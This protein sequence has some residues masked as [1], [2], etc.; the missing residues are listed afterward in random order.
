MPRALPINQS[1]YHLDNVGRLACTFATPAG[2]AV[3]PTTVSLTVKTPTTETTYVYGEDAE[4]QRSEAGSYFADID[5]DEE[6]QW[7]YRWHS[8]GSGKAA[9]ENPLFVE[10]AYAD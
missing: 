5:L 10:L 1:R 8:T 9:D 6:G 4:M 3:D 2:V 7:W